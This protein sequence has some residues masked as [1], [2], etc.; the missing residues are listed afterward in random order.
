MYCLPQ[1]S[2][3]N[4]RTFLQCESYLV[5][6]IMLIILVNG[7]RNIDSYVEQKLLDDEINSVL[8]Q[9]PDVSSLQRRSKNINCSSG[10][11]M[12]G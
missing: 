6:M 11:T 7:G 9:V 2:G 3:K 10:C 4:P 1:N 8:L 5:S 12:L